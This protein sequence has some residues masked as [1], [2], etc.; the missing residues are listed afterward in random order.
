MV[1]MQLSRALLVGAE[2]LGEG[3]RGYNEVWGRML[4]LSYRTP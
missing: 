1:A 4:L 2:S 3:K